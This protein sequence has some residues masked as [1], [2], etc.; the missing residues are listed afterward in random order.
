MVSLRPTRAYLAVPAHRARLVAKAAASLADA[1]FMDLEDAVPPNEKALALEEAARALSSLHWGNKHVAVRLN[2]VDS[3]FI[4]EEIRTLAA[5]PRLDAVIVPKAE[6]VSDIV[7]IADQLHAAA[8]DR[9]APLAL[10]LLIETALGLV[11]V[12]ALAACH[13]SVAALHLGVGDLAASLG[14]RTSDIG[15]SPDGYRHVGSAQSGYAAAPLDLFAYPMM[16][17]L[18]AARARGL[19]AID[20]PCGAFRD[21][22]LTEASAQK[23]AAMGFDGKQVI[24]PDQIEPTLR[25]FTPSAEELAQARRVVEAMEQ[26]EALGQGAVTLDGKMIDYANVRMARRII[27]LGS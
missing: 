9:A 12:D 23:A 25:A 3:S 15:I 21:A 7:A 19:R 14:A 13:D 16:R 1:V 10:E 2:A 17:L 22:R 6:R 11:N 24:H 18:V 4:A 26:A 20:G 27:E 5:L 8:P